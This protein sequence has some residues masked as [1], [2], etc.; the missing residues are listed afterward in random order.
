MGR[1]ADDDEQ[2]QQRSGWLL[3]LSVLAILLILSGALVIYYLAPPTALFAN[4]T[5]PTSASDPVYL[6]IAG[7][8]FAIPANF[9]PY[10][11][12][13]RGGEQTEAALFALLPD[14]AGWSPKTADEFASNAADSR[15]VFLRLHA[16]RKGLSEPAKLARVYMDYVES[17]EGRPG[18]YGLQHYAFRQDS[19]YRDED[20]F[21]GVGPVVLRCVRP[22][23]DV[24]SPNCLREKT[25]SQGLSLS[26]RFKRSQL[27][28]WRPM[29]QRIDALIAGFKAEARP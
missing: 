5:S 2:I 17:R 25:V 23:P 22:S 8:A 10:P 26:Y 1:T 6:S 21:V 24:P 13:R 27:A 14:L 4:R 15:V 16:E 28:Q 20:L 3:P 11:A 29:A 18:P 19:G 9:L 12:A 7:Q